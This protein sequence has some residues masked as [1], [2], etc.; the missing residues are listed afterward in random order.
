MAEPFGFTDPLSV[1]LL[2]PTEVA[3]S[4][5]ALGNSVEV[6]VNWSAMLTADVPPEVVTVTSTV[7]ADSSGLIAVME[8]D[9]T[10]AKL[11]A[12]VVPKSTV[13]APV[14]P[15]PVMVT[16]VPPAVVP[17]IGLTSVTAGVTGVGVTGAVVAVYAEVQLP[18][19]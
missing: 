4:V 9:E 15:V 13:V 19:L 7:P 18:A 3:A 17:E 11:V 10:T 14:K 1:A 5:V 8:V 6:K 12:L 16:L 2:E